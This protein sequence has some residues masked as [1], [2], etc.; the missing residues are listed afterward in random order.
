MKIE[1]QASLIFGITIDA[2]I[3]NAINKTIAIM[4]LKSC[5]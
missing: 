5:P 1:Y 3:T 4:T 2:Q